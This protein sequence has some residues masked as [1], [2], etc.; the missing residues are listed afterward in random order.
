[1]NPDEGTSACEPPD[2][3]QFPST[4]W[5]TIL[6][7]QDGDVATMQEAMGKLCTRYQPA[8]L[9]YFRLKWKSYQRWA[10]VQDAQDLTQSF[11]QHLLEA[12]RLQALDPRKVRRFRHYLI[13][14]LRNFL[15]D[16]ISGQQALR[17]GGGQE[18][19]CL[20][21]PGSAESIEIAIEDPDIDAS[22]SRR[23]AVSVHNSVVSQLRREAGDSIRFE[24]LRR[25]LLIQPGPGDYARAAQELAVSQDV[26]KASVKRWLGRYS[27]LFL[28][29]FRQVVASAPDDIQ[30][31]VRE[32][33]EALYRAVELGEIEP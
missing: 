9:S 13:K 27:E 17:R 1:M 28:A 26:V 23:F 31:E 10:H 14:A 20:Q 2:P 7:A 30:G 4:H 22:F 24:R 11:I 29:E 33:L 12:P 21:Q 16:W 15:S 3:V 8:I 5:K 18:I 25:F 32:M 6:A 19:L